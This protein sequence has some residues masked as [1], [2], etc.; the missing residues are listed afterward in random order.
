MI[1]VMKVLNGIACDDITSEG[2]FGEDVSDII[3][4]IMSSRSFKISLSC[5]ISEGEG[6]FW[7][8]VPR[9]LSSKELSG[10]QLY[11]FTFLL[12]T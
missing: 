11:G 8:L 1:C 7:V 3:L 2:E 4:A 5:L 10:G 6:S 12:D 9:Y